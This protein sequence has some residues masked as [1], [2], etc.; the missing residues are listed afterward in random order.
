MSHASLRLRAECAAALRDYIE[1]QSEA[2]LEHAYGIGRQAMV[3]G[4]GVVDVAMVHQEALSA[5]LAVAERPGNGR[6]GAGDRSTQPAAPAPGLPPSNRTTTAARA[7]EF[8]AEC[9]SPFEMELRGFREANRHLREEVAE[10]ARA[11]AE[12][13]QLNEGLERR[14]AERTAE[15]AAADRQKDRF[16]A[17]LSHELRN[18]LAA[19]GSAARL[20]Q[21]YLPA[22]PTLRSARDVIDRQVQHMTRLLEDLLDVSRVAHGKVELRKDPV[23]LVSI[24]RQ[25]AR[26]VEPT[27]QARRHEFSVSLSPGPLRVEGDP[28]R[29]CQILIN[30]LDNAAKYTGDGGTIRLEAQCEELAAR[31]AEPG[32][33]SGPPGTPPPG[34]AALPSPRFAVIR[35][36]DNGIGIAPELLP[37]VFNLFVQANASPAHSQGGLGLGLS[38]VRSLAEMHGGSVAACSE[39]RGQGSEFVVRLPLT[40]AGLEERCAEL[41]AAGNTPHCHRILVV[42]DNADFAEMLAALLETCGHEVRVAPDGAAALEA[43]ARFR[44]SV[45]LLDLGLPGMSGHEVARCL[46]ERMEPGDARLIAISGYG[47]EEDRRRSRQAGFDEHLTK[48]V[49]LDELAP[50]LA[51][52]PPPR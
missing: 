17:F 28:A 32:A 4:L 38:L 8:L 13:R 11:E 19:I 3:E 48:P 22:N 45:V 1:L 12:V 2:A 43:A 15:L 23:D 52:A 49:G 20:I 26:V 42:D 29:L 18:P 50:L 30:I 36:R 5:V 35:V 51:A 24:V 33:E 25:A 46:R 21:A 37:R 39:G 7:A 34:S 16:L 47:Q 6:Q 31:S 14:V 10:R 40:S 27:M 9:L 41:A 44:P